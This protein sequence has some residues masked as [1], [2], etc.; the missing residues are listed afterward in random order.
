MGGEDVAQPTWMI[1]EVPAQW[2]GDAEVRSPALDRRGRCRC[3]LDL[4]E[5]AG[6]RQW[7]ARE[8]RAHVVGQILAPPA[9]REREQLRYERRNDPR[10]DPQCEQNRE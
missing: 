8:L 3:P 10:D 6:Q 9:D 4:L 1:G 2:I 7:I 5:C